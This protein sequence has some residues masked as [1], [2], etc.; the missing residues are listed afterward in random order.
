MSYKIIADTSSN[1]YQIEGV[2]FAYA[3]MKIITSEKEFVDDENVN[4]NDFIQYLSSYKGKTT[5]SCPNISDWLTHFE[6]EDEIYA[7][8]ITSNLSGCHNACVQAKNAYLQ[9]HP[10]AKILIIDSLSAGPELELLITKI[11]ELKNEGK[12][13]EEVCTYMEAYQKRTHLTFML[14]SVNNLANNGRVNPALAKVIGFLSIRIVGRASNVGT[15]E[16][17]HKLKGTKKCL[18]TLLSEMEEHHYKGGKVII[19]HC[20]NEKEAQ[21][22]ADM[23]E[24]KYHT[25]PILRHTSAL[26]SFYAEEGGFL[27]GYEE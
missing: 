25:K 13:F 9:D 16:P 2:N 11:V 27:V 20:N 5:T 23:I 7:V 8:T 15:L 22:F 10:E 4:I 1:L 24:A 18:N 17:I 12:T 14:K 26:C 19:S 21:S 3:P 6:N